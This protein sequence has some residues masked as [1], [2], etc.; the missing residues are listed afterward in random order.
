MDICRETELKRL[1]KE[2]EIDKH[3]KTIKSQ[4]IELP[5]LIKQRKKAAIELKQA[6]KTAK[7]K[8]K[9]KYAL[10][11]FMDDIGVPRKGISEVWRMN[12]STIKR[13]V[14][15]KKTNAQRPSSDISKNA[16]LDLLD[17][18]EEY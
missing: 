3:T 17:S 10:I 2:Q 18:D 15:L 16:P 7:G 5:L 13:I 9:V 1:I 12:L 14:Y 8:R 4:I 11:R 6:I